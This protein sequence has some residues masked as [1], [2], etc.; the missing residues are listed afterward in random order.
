MYNKDDSP[1]INFNEMDVEMEDHFNNFNISIADIILVFSFLILFSIVFLQF[2]TRY[3]LN[4]SISWTEEAARYLLII[5]AFAGAIRCQIYDRHITLEFMDKY[6]GK[7]KIYFVI[8]SLIILFFFSIFLSIS[9][10]TLADKTMFL[11]MVSLPFP[12]FYLHYLIIAFLVINSLVIARQIIRN[13]RT[14]SKGKI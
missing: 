3:V 11:K 1:E 14:I 13:I 12:K 9:A 7:F 10:F 8:F 2:F 4:D 5:V 6:Y